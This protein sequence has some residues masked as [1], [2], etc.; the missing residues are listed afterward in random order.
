M[1][2][3]ECEACG[4][5]YLDTPD[6]Y[7]CDKVKTTAEVINNLKDKNQAL[8]KIIAQ[9]N[10]YSNIIDEIEN[11]IEYKC[12]ICRSDGELIPCDYC[13]KMQV[14]NIIHKEMKE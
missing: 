5:I 10:K 12:N 7:V 1:S 4:A 8:K 14:L 13:F 2:N 9:Q 6:G 11:L 3:F